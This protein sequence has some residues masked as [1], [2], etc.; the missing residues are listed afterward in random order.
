LNY[1][2]PNRSKLDVRPYTERI[3]HLCVLRDPQCPSPPCPS[4]ALPRHTLS[5]L[6][7]QSSKETQ[8]HGLKRVSELSHNICILYCKS[9]ISLRF[10]PRGEAAGKQSLSNTLRENAWEWLT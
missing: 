10:P 1:L 6:S 3:I 9:H 2:G 4:R 5:D 7:L 8:F